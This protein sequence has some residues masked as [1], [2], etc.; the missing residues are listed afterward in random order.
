MY[1]RQHYG[2]T[3]DS[4]PINVGDLIT[5]NYVDNLFSDI[6]KIARHQSGTNTFEIA[7]VTTNNTYD[8]YV[9][10]LVSPTGVV[11]DDPDGSRK[12][13]QTYYDT[14]IGLQN[15][16]YL[17][18]DS[19]VTAVPDLLTSVRSRPWRG[20]VHGE[21]GIMFT[22]YI[23]FNT[24]RDMELFLNTGCSISVDLSLANGETVKSSA[25]NQLCNEATGT[26]FSELLN[27]WN[28]DIVFGGIR[29]YRSDSITLRVDKVSSTRFKVT[30][31]LIDGTT[32]SGNNNITGVL[33]AAIR[34]GVSN[35]YWNVIG[36][37][38]V[39]D[40]ATLT[41]DVDFE[42]FLPPPTYNL[43]LP[44][45]VDE[46]EVITATL[47]T[48]FLADGSAVEYSISGV[49]ASDIKNMW[50]NGN[51]IPVTFNGNFVVYGGTST[52]EI[53]TEVDVD[54]TEKRLTVSLPNNQVQKST[55]I[56]QIVLPINQGIWCLSVFDEDS[57]G[58][59]YVNSDYRNFRSNYPDRRIF[60]LQTREYALAT[61]P[62]GWST[63][64]LARGPIRINRDRGDPSRASDWY[65][66]CGLNR[67]PD[68][69]AVALSI[70]NSGSMRTSHVRA[71]LDLLR[72]K[73][74]ARN[75]QL[76]VTNM[77]AERV[78]AGHVRNY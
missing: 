10:S 61:L 57:S 49:F 71:S 78:I 33:T 38:D 41:A 63:D 32:V 68:N 3:L 59:R 56:R 46:G 66:L 42:D 31:D 19:Q 28:S 76:I 35:F 47:E 8:P 7:R 23:D 54:D 6:Q 77:P 17:V 55:A 43:T 27:N 50:L 5:K 75:I 48:E 15:D 20:G 70:D 45:T 72:R 9:S 53:E 69:Y 21:D 40:V 67:V 62:T 26:K 74:A 12:G 58:A 65:T 52:L 44:R 24:P 34:F 2:Q 60:L 18:D 4:S 51:P 14:L 25:W 16:L 73:L 11:F 1:K 37:N 22:A 30:V 36:S 39:T 64:P 13:I 29:Y